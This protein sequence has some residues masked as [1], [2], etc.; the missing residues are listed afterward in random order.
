MAETKKKS[1]GGLDPEVKDDFDAY[2]SQADAANASE[3]LA[4]LLET[5][6]VTSSV[7]AL[8]GS[9]AKV[10]GMVYQ[11]FDRAKHDLDMALILDHE[12]IDAEHDEM[13]AKI[14]ELTQSLA[15]RDTAIAGQVAELDELRAKAATVDEIAQAMRDA[16]D[17]AT[18]R[19]EAQVVRFDKAM[20]LLE[21]Q[22]KRYEDELA[23]VNAR[24]A[25]VEQERD[26]MAH[27][28]RKLQGQLDEANAKL[29]EAGHTGQE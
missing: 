12:M 18:K 20:A 21:S 27:C 11:L 13:A 6:K 3:A 9:A 17:A 4:K 2:Q 25:E 22:V 16:A 19:E 10:R 8:D 1:I 14:E 26:E 28:V 15:E 23:K 7:V 24:L 5:A 29:A